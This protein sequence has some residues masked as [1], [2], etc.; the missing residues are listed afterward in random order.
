MTE[1]VAQAYAQHASRYVAALGSL[2][3]MDPRDLSLL[4]SWGSGVQGLL[5]D[6]GCGPGHWTEL[7]RTRGCEAIGVDL[8]PEFIASARERFPR[9]SFQLGDIRSLPLADASCGGVLSWYSIIHTQ[10]SRAA[11]VLAEFAR[12]LR[13]RTTLL[14]GV[15]QGSPRG[16]VR[17]RHHESL[18]L[19]TA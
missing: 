5:L 4:S 3:E 10:P 6:A 11:G 18:L 14:L 19:V 17:P 7:L 8:V 2:A 13:P 12:L 1:P 16:R 15:F 9:A